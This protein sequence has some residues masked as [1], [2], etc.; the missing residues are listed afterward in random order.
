M[1]SA[2]DEA[3]DLS[4]NMGRLRL[5]GPVAPCG[6][7][8]V[9]PARAIARPAHENG[10]P[11]SV[12]LSALDAACAG[13]AAAEPGTAEATPGAPTTP[14]LAGVVGVQSL[15]AAMGAGAEQEEPA[16]PARTAAA[17]DLAHA[18]A[19]IPAGAAMSA[20]VGGGIAGP[21]ATAAVPD[22]A[23]GEGAALA[24][25]PAQARAASLAAAGDGVVRGPPAESVV[26]GMEEPLAA[27]RE[28]IGAR[29]RLVVA[30][31]GRVT[32]GHM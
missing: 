27:L 4:D 2:H 15:G 31:A 25:A 6:S 23:D 30:K 14:K 3:G 18:V 29:Q 7:S 26:A 22:L 11:G 32:C 1:A 16:G 19:S 20:A 9:L 10:G 28:L 12:H 24:G 21:A 13:T 17:P 5:D 8:S